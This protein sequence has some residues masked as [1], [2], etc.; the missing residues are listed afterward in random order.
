MTRSYWNAIID[1]NILCIASMIFY[2]LAHSIHLY[3]EKLLTYDTF[4]LST[5]HCSTNIPSAFCLLSWLMLWWLC[6]MLLILWYPV[7]VL[8]WLYEI[9]YP[10]IYS[11][12]KLCASWWWYSTFWRVILTIGRLSDLFY[13]WPAFWSGDTI[14]NNRVN[15]LL[16]VLFIVLLLMEV[17]IEHSF[18][19]SILT[20]GY[21]YFSVP[22]LH[23]PVHLVFILHQYVEND[24][25]YKW[26]VKYKL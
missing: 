4:S 26:N 3:E 13:L 7:V 19:L 18:I 5:L 8:A 25:H 11:L 21:V 22:L 17:Y 15:S 16:S 1:S 2:I 24:I 20:E 6:H 9:Q 12:M 14:M 10:V 23:S